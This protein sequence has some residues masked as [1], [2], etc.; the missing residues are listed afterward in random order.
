LLTEII[1]TGKL[2][3]LL[4]VLR[5]TRLG[6]PLPAAIAAFDRWPG[7]AAWSFWL[8]SLN[9]DR[10]S[11]RES[12]VIWFAGRTPDRRYKAQ[13]GSAT[14]SRLS[15]SSRQWTWGAFLSPI[16]CLMSATLSL[17]NL[18]ALGAL[19]APDFTPSWISFG[20]AIPLAC[21]SCCADVDY[22]REPRPLW[23]NRATGSAADAVIFAL[24]VAIFVRQDVGA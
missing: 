10:L 24:F 19:V 5:V 17:G 9:M 23:R 3:L 12:A 18:L 11:M 22:C 14:C 4:A 8:I 16:C 2:S 15:G 20:S 21:S 13:D 1:I 7:D 6:L